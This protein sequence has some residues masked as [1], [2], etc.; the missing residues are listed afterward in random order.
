ME[1]YLPHRHGGSPGHDLARLSVEPPSDV[2]DFSVNLNPL[3]YPDV[4]RNRWGGLLEGVEH[5]PST[6]GEGIAL[7]LKSRFGVAAGQ[8]L[9]G[10]GSTEFIYLIPRA[11]GLRRIA[12]VTPSYHDYYR[13]SLMA[14]AGVFFIPLLPEEGFCPP[15]VER[16][17][18][19][20]ENADALWLGNPNN[21][22]GTFFPRETLS[23]LAARFPE[24]LLIVD[25]AFM[26]FLRDWK[27]ESMAV[28]PFPP[29][30]ITIHSLTKFYGLAGL[31]LGG[32]IGPESLIETLRK[33]KEPWT[34]NSVSE[35][36]SPF[37]LE[38]DEYERE[39]LN[40]VERERRR[41]LQALREMPSLTAFDSKANFLLCRWDRG[42][43][44]DPLL[45]GLLRLGIY[46]RDCRN[47]PGLEDGY[48][49][50]AVRRSEDNSR[51]IEGLSVVSGE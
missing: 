8:A 1:P 46:V 48:F 2:I 42:P 31:R 27:T 4:V 34:A 24:K 32:V 16:L 21:P 30:V 11:L 23:H 9:G 44:L 28:P 45:R 18:Q 37:L 22:T 25:E 50:V 20:L 43:E 40:L 7:Y 17:A 38:C 13:A 29:N 33:N 19:A 26:L 36:L 39:T 51:L 15:S 6:E 14:G 35:S 5:Y 47:F 12:I 10:N 49:R 41:L 3:G